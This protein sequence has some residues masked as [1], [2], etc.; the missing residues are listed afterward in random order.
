MKNNERYMV[1]VRKVSDGKGK[2]SFETLILDNTRLEN[3]S[4]ILSVKDRLA[5][6]IEHA[7][8]VANILQTYVYLNNIDVDIRNIGSKYPKRVELMKA[9]QANLA[10]Y[11]LSKN[12][13]VSAQL[14]TLF[15]WA[16]TYQM[17][18]ETTI[19]QSCKNG[20]IKTF[21]NG[22]KNPS[23]VSIDFSEKQL[24]I[25]KIIDSELY[26]FNNLRLSKAFI[27]GSEAYLV[28]SFTIYK[29]MKIDLKEDNE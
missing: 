22:N 2:K 12:S 6:A 17:K 18:D 13:R 28:D 5:E 16:V 9:Y 11:L 26:D 19:M 4:V 29:E 27:K 21:I 8:E 1:A 3:A 14:M 24:F 10:N 23:L 15:D 20:E 7:I 25:P